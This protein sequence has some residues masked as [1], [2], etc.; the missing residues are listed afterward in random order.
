[1]KKLK[2]L[3][4]QLRELSINQPKKPKVPRLIYNDITIEALKSNLAHNWPSGG[5]MSN[6]AGIVFG[7]YTMNQD[8]I[9]RT[10]GSFNQLWDGGDIRTDRQTTESSIV[11][12]AR[13]TVSLQIQEA[14]LKKFI[15]SSGN[16]AR[17][18]GLFA[19]FLIAYPKSTQGTRLYK[20][21]P[22]KWPGLN[23]FNNRILD[24]LKEEIPHNE[25]EEMN[26]KMLQ[27]SPEAKK[28]WIEFHDSIEKELGTSGEYSD[29]KDVAS[30]IA[31]NAARIAGLFHVFEY[32]F[33]R[34]IGIKTFVDA[35]GIALWHLHEA[36]RFFCNLPLSEEEN[37]I[38]KLNDWL[39][40]RCQKAGTGMIES[41]EIQQCGPN[42]IRKKNVLDMALKRL[43]ELGRVQL[44]GKKIFINPALLQ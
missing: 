34:S 29:I 14:P 2:N 37:N 39:I 11:R 12:N 22:D 36:K 16:L 5:I 21:S 7:G 41:R 27:F 8:S 20:E 4:D 44:N 18:I 23:T 25:L 33:E 26:P 42:S 3:E 15:E 10:L 28:A 24:I 19:R 38:I 13:L 31:D 32:G 30:K 6:E 1:M 9:M 43:K 35:S 17:E 40:S